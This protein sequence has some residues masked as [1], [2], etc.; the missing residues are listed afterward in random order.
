MKSQVETN[1]RMDGGSISNLPLIENIQSKDNRLVN[2]NN[3]LPSL[4]SCDL[5]SDDQSLIGSRTLSGDSQCLE[6]YPFLTVI[7]Q[8][9]LNN[10]I[11]GGERVLIDSVR[12]V[13][14][15][16][17]GEGDMIFGLKNNRYFDAD[18]QSIKSMDSKLKQ[19]NE[20]R[21]GRPPLD[22]SDYF[23]QICSATKTPQWRYISVCS[24]ESKLRVCNACW[25][26][27]RKKRDGKCLPL[28]IGMSNNLNCSNIGGLLKTSKIGVNKENYDSQRQSYTRG[29]MSGV[30]YKISGIVSK[31]I[32]ANGRSI[33]I[34]NGVSK[35]C[36]AVSHDLVDNLKTY[37]SND[38]LKN[39]TVSC[40]VNAGMS[41][42]Q[43]IKPISFR[44]SPY[45]VSTATTCSNSTFDCQSCGS[46]RCYCSSLI[47]PQGISLTS[48]V[49]S[50]PLE[51]SGKLV[52]G[53]NKIKM[54]CNFNKSIS[55]DKLSSLDLVCG[56]ANATGMNY[57]NNG[58]NSSL[59]LN[60]QCNQNV[61]I[62]SNKL[63]ETHV[64]ERRNLVENFSISE[65]LSFDINCGIE[66]G[67]SNIKTGIEESYGGN[68]LKVNASNI[69]E[70]SPINSIQQSPKQNS[71]IDSYQSRI[72]GKL[73]NGL[74]TRKCS[75]NRNNFISGGKFSVSTPVHHQAS[76]TVSPNTNYCNIS[77]YTSSPCQ[78]FPTYDGPFLED[79]NKTMYISSGVYFYPNTETN[80][81]TEETPVQSSVGLN[82]CVGNS[83]TESEEKVEALSFPLDQD[84]HN[85]LSQNNEP[86]E[87]EQANYTIF[88]K[89]LVNA[90]SWNCDYLHI[91]MFCIP[92][93]DK[94]P[95][96]SEAST[97]VPHYSVGSKFFNSSV[98]CTLPTVYS[99]EVQQEDESSSQ[100]D[101]NSWD[102][103]SSSISCMD[104]WQNPLWYDSYSNGFCKLS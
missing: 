26:K 85:T 100:N 16:S 97:S 83:N 52:P 66:T 44:S 32:I 79:P 54:H 28:Q 72:G 77:S 48:T 17:N 65:K 27:Q 91:D 56:S 68:C 89:H 64:D 96:S 88:N 38:N 71:N 23:C 41:N 78:S 46:Q 69:S 11:S 102:F 9:G 104:T 24:V 59:D 8:Q 20:R 61:F 60:N 45:S 19:T 92:T 13:G 6:N 57:K 103:D 90:E 43:C 47:G 80:R 14:C 55:I 98:S 87:H 95:I 73:N 1:Q 36:K 7:G 82:S 15:D 84:T 4:V 37:V 29:G 3:I 70:E 42:G 34:T 75:D 99:A 30:G 58:S 12:N 74:L 50:D 63:S 62:D 39:D 10:T 94:T 101:C 31:N 51:G 2:R 67:E 53:P 86:I 18:I 25:M 76:T 33:S 5:L 93:A 40:N 81:W 21:A 49:S 22:R 35:D